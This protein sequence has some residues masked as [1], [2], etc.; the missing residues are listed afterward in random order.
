LTHGRNLATSALSLLD[1]TP[2]WRRSGGRIELWV[3]ST[4]DMWMLRISAIMLAAYAE[5]PVAFWL[6]D[7]IALDLDRGFCGGR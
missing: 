3:S 5:M 2:V 6:V 7:D 1:D 4:I